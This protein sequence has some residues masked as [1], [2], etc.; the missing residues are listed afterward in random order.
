MTNYNLQDPYDITL[1]ESDFASISQREWQE[2]FDYASLGDNWKRFDKKALYIGLKNAGRYDRVSPKQ[3]VWALSVAEAIQNEKEKRLKNI[4]IEDKLD[5][6]VFKQPLR[7]FTIR[8][9]WHDS[10]WNGTIC[11]DPLANRYCSGYN[12]LLSERIRRNKE[13]N[14]ELEK[15]YAGKKLTKIDYLPPCYWSINLNGDETIKVNHLNPAAIKELEPIEETLKDNSIFSWPFAISFNR[16]NKEIKSEGAYP[17]NLDN[18][19]IPLFREKVKKGESVAFIY[20]KFSNPFTEEER[21]YLVIG[22][23]IVEDKG[24]LLS[25]GPMEKIEAKRKI[26]FPKNKNF[27]VK[28]WALQF[29][30]DE[31]TKVFMPYHEYLEKSKSITDSKLRQ[32][33][34]DKIK[35][36]ITETELNHCFKYVAMDIN[37]DEAIY[38]LSKMRQKLIDCKNDGIVDPAEMNR[39]IQQV[40]NL[41]KHCWKHRGY[42]PGFEV[43]AEQLLQR[44]TIFSEFITEIKKFEGDEQADKIVELLEDPKSDS[45]FKKYKNDLYEL[46]ETLETRGITA[47]KFLELTMLNLTKHQFKRILEGKVKDYDS[48]R[49]KVDVRD[50]TPLEEICANPYLLVE[51]YLPEENIQDENTGEELDYPIELFKVDIAYFPDGS[52]MPRL[53]IQRTMSL[54]DKRRLRCLIINYL[55]SLEQTGDCF[56]EALE[57]ENALRKYPLFYQKGAEFIIP[58]DILKKIVPDRDSFFEEQNRKLK[59]ID[60]ND[61]RYYY[62]YELYWTEKIIGDCINELLDQPKNEIIYDNLEKY[63]SDCTLELG[64]NQT[65]NKEDFIAERSVLYKNLFRER[66]YVLAGG[67]GSG[68][69][70]ELLNIIKEIE[71]QGENYTILAPTGKATLRLK[72]D[73]IFPGIEASTIDKWLTEIKNQRI[74]KENI[75]RINNLIIDE[76]S[77]VDLLKFHQVLKQFQ[78]SKPSFKRLIL[79]GDPNQLPAIGYGKVL[80]D[81]L[82]YLKSNKN[83]TTNYIELTGNLRSELSENK[84]I[85]LSQAFEEKGEAEESIEKLIERKSGDIKIS[86]GFKCIFW[87]DEYELKSKI[88]NEFD[89]LCEKEKIK[90]EKDELLSQIFGL[91][92]KGTI[93]NKEHLRLDYFQL[94]TPY[95]SGLSGANGLNDYFQ[96]HYKAKLK[97]SLANGSFKESDKIIRTKNYYDYEEEKLL[98]SNGSIGL[99]QNE[100]NEK[101]YFL[102]NNYEEIKLSDIRKAE[103]DFFEL[104]YAISIH[105]SQGSG[106]DHLFIII[107]DRL[108]LLSRELVYTAL[109]RCR[110]SV[111]LFVQTTQEK[112][113]SKSLL[114]LARTRTFTDGRKTTL[115]LNQPF[116][117]Y[118]LEPEE[119]VFVQSRTELM[120]YHALKKKRLEVGSNEFDFS[121]EKYPTDSAGNE[122]KIKTDF[123]IVSKGNIWYWEHLGRLGNRIYERNWHNLKHPTYKANN[124]ESKMITTDELRGLSTDK[125]DFI[126]EAIYLNNIVSEDK[127]NK[128]SLNHYSLR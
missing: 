102:E 88:E 66:I 86:E 91:T 60:A 78:F 93:G 42:F 96:E 48:Y 9:A 75:S 53:D 55:R 59:I 62:L 103:R 84:V 26:R 127:T 58:T 34:L 121:Y 30:L 70:H 12:S 47:D 119:G 89:S 87:N 83:F 5:N 113:K 122:I 72:S 23:A 20:A 76:M 24:D 105:K 85:E 7:H 116:R 39:R 126:V 107:P 13:E 28:N 101:L 35:V 61:T 15:K 38:I 63:I 114:G 115:L 16:T 57:L 98:L 6:N 111:V 74:S 2:Y 44:E 90:G 79:V 19:R 32:D 33:L 94:L 27:P 95:L 52:V 112:S 8:V 41:I 29:N 50:K 25:F 125:I 99:I 4:D 36:A 100:N 17:P 18:V 68:K 77:M 73:K 80:K 81:I 21:Q 3:M 69:S 46:K 92:K 128:Y 49:H 67:P 43:L 118:S 51:E 123:T 56:E 65:F 40:E 104:A 64:S 37:D 1:L 14:I 45:D 106:F 97:F 117:Y 109:T 124:L 10:A 110:K 11:K 108:G 54:S 22:V 120:I 82:Y 71:R 31:S